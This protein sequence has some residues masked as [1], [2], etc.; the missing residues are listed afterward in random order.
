[1]A[2]SSCSGP[3]LDYKRCEFAEKILESLKGPC[4]NSNH[5]CNE[6]VR[7]SEKLQHEKNCIYTQCSCPCQDCIFIS[8]SDKLLEHLYSEHS[9]SFKDFKFKDS[10]LFHLEN[11]KK[12]SNTVLKENYNGDLFVL[13]NEVSRF[14]IVVTVSRVDPRWSKGEF[15]FEIRADNG[16]SF[17]RLRSPMNSIRSQATDPFSMNFILIP[18]AFVSSLP[19]FKLELRIWP[20]EV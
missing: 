11:C 7:F 14:G 3:T 2:C 15:F 4:Q 6:T 17:I 8:S 16:E 18:N 10:C 13:T 9:N 5:G 1:M 19:N 12:L 20:V